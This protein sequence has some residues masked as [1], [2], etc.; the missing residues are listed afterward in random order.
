MWRFR[1]IALL[2]L[3]FFSL[4]PPF[5]LLAFA[6]DRFKSARLVAI[7]DVVSGKTNLG[8]AKLQK[9]SKAGD[10]E[11][12]ISLG[13][14]HLTVEEIKSLNQ[15]EL[16]YLE[17]LNIECHPS[18]LGGLKVLYVTRGS[19]LFDPQKY[20]KLEKKC[21]AG[22]NVSKDDIR[23]RRDAEQRE[24]KKQGDAQ[25]QS[26]SEQDQ[27][28]FDHEAPSQIVISSELMDQWA[29]NPMP[30][31]EPISGGSAVALND[32]GYF[33]TNHH[34]IDGCPTVAVIYNGL[35]GVAKVLAWSKELDLA[36]VDANAPTPFFAKF[37]LKRP[38]VG[39]EL[40]ALGYPVEEIFGSN[41][42]FS[43]GHLTNATERE[44]EI[45]PDGF[46]LISIP[47][48][49]GNSGGPIFTKSLGLRGIAVGGINP[50]KLA[51]DIEKETGLRLFLEST[52][53]NL[54]VS[55]KHA[56][57]WLTG[58]GLQLETPKARPR[59]Q[60][61]QDLAESGTRTLGKVICFE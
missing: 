42:S 5:S 60:S 32:S 29:A 46:L 16:Y 50:S 39:E 10:I 14:L 47:L 44:T 20:N 9:L 55:P 36:V 33:L 57:D 6:E 17:A 56:Y 22:M 1:V 35:S 7:S 45:K 24:A 51:N 41:P 34:V 8:I 30:R 21:R 40:F 4:I 15:A 28:I 58:L 37:D 18:A 54:M 23:N 52:T 48:A 61:L 25:D 38:R 59:S 26:V 49:N 31:A 27:K 53:L 12:L 3:L 43:L 11:S 19:K 2:G 13:V